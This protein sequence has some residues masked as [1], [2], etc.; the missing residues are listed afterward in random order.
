L[1]KIIKRKFIYLSITILSVGTI[2]GFK[3]KAVNLLNGISESPYEIES[4]GVERW[5]VK[6]LSDADASSVNLV[7]VN[8][9]VKDLI[10]IS[11]P[12][13]DPN[14]PRQACEKQIYIVHCTVAEI[15]LESDGDYH[16][17]MQDSA[18]NTMIGEIPDPTCPST[19][20]S[21]YLGDITRC[22]KF[23]D[24]HYNV[25]TSFQS[26][27]KRFVITGVS[28]VDPPHGQSDAAPNNLEIHSILDIEFE[29]V[30]TSGIAEVI[31]RKQNLNVF[32]NPFS[33]D[34]EFRLDVAS[35]LKHK[36]SI[37]KIFDL[38]GKEMKSIAWPEN[39]MNIV[40]HRDN[41]P[42]GIYLYR[43]M[44]GNDIVSTGKIMAE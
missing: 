20:S 16:L 32:P 8:T 24:S 35:S 21:L 13:P 39:E 10:H 43:L 31:D 41:L 5:S 14:M 9:T 25:G 36:N 40:F 29:P 44:E 34:A 28:F 2:V 15:K 12:F 1:N 26:V 37:L 6:V 38:S 33:E 42:R 27:N 19:T 18:G 17:L 11:T 23:I 7:P 30:H 22:R 3:D 4:C